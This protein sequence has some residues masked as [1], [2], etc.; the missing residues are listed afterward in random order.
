MAKSL[1]KLLIVEDD[2]GLQSQ[3]KWCFDDRELFLADN[4]VQ[5]LDLF[6]KERPK[7]IITDL[8]LPPDPG[9]S[10]E[11]FALIEEILSIDESVK[12]VVVTG[13]E[14]RANAVQAIGLGAYDFYQKP[15]DVDTLK[16]V[17]NRAFRLSELETENQKL[18]QTQALTVTEGMIGSSVQLT[19]IMRTTDKVA[20]TSA[21]LLVLGESGTGKGMLAKRVHSLSDRNEHHLVTINCTSIPESLLESELF[22]HEK[23][24]F[25]GAVA[26]K[27]GKIEYAN[28]GTLFLDE[29]GDMPMALQAKILHVLQEK[30][31]VRLGGVEEIPLDIRVICATHQN[32]KQ[33]ISQSLFREDLYYRISEIVVEMP[34]LRD[35]TEDILLLAQ[36]FLQR[37][38]EQM[39]RKSNKF[40]QDAMSALRSYNWP[41]NIRELEN[42][43]KRAVVMSEKSLIS[44]ADLE[45]EGVHQ[46][47]TPMALSDVRAKA[48]SEAIIT[49]LNNCKNL[50]DAA[51]LLGVTRPTLYSLIAKYELEPHVTSGQ[52]KSP[53]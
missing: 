13:R 45:L 21:N 25:T 46:E 43:I 40:S 30:T 2:P 24:A 1:P 5:A 17:V 7:V 20:A 35:R 28:G 14:E 36:A 8:G 37:F 48:E 26:R 9:G 31:I 51:K 38:T 18:L 23:G 32:L 47:F 52:Q 3:L 22:G 34:P 11:G 12:V 10:S 42:K 6:R 16:F 33:R 53:E 49:T 39:G 27:I 29:I 15:I 44:V 19:Q 50:S 41:G 4:R